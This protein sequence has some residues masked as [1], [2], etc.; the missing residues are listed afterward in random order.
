MPRCVSEKPG[1]NT[2]TIRSEALPTAS[3]RPTT[4]KSPPKAVFQKWSATTT[5]PSRPP[6]PWNTPPAAAF[7]PSTSK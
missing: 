5:T 4:F 1:C 3:V 7:T 6:P 2:P